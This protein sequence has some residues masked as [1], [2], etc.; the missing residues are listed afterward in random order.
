MNS[1]KEILKIKTKTIYPNTVK[2]ISN[3]AAEIFVFL[4][5]FRILP[6]EWLL[7]DI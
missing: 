4:S 6:D 5:C 3:S 7:Y 1:V 2:A